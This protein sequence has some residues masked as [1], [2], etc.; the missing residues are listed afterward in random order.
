MTGERNM[1]DRLTVKP[2]KEKW[3]PTSDPTLRS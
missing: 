2:P 3:W 1:I